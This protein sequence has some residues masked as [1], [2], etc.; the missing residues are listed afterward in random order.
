MKSFT[1]L[2]VMGIVTVFGFAWTLGGF[3][4]MI[5]WAVQGS[6]LDVVLSMIIPM[7]GAI[8]VLVDLW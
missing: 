2:L 4:G 3:I 7:Y 6:L 1:E 8:S 5:Y